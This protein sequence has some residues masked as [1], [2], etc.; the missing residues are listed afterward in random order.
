MPINKKNAI[1]M[2]R[3]ARNI[4]YHKL[5]KSYPIIVAL[6]ANYRCNEK[7]IFCGHPS[8]AYMGGLPTEEIFELIDQ[9]DELKIPFCS[10]SGGEPLLRSDIVEIGD[11]LLEK[12]IKNSLNTN[13]TLITKDL[14][15]QLS[16]SY[17]SIVVSLDGLKKTHEQ[18]RGVKNC[19]ESTM[20]GIEY[21]HSAKDTNLVG[22]NFVLNKYNYN[23]L[24]PLTKLLLKKK[25]VD[26]IRITA[27]KHEKDLKPPIDETRAIINHILKIKKKHPQFIKP[28]EELLMK[29]PR[30]FSGEYFPCD[31]GK[32]YCT[33]APNGDVYVCDFINEAFPL[34]NFRNQKLKY[35][36]KS[37]RMK[38]VDRIKS[39]CGG[40]LFEFAIGFSDVLNSSPL[41]LAKNIP[42]FIKDG[43][44][45]HH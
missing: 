30:F 35:I 14:A 17:E 29:I 43:Y 41:E 21:L 40:C 9:I 27:V 13:G 36:L 32:L 22:I 1:F 10:V 16:G 15:R 28:S 19:F 5:N 45:L 31:A 37:E 4:L 25:L 42:K 6:L 18:L 26:F 11:Y 34:G 12:N 23:D 2:Y 39:Q 3:V 7:C 44:Y 8:R 24:I 33:I 20:R 38:E